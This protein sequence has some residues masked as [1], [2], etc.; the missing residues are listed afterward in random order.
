VDRLAGSVAGRVGASV[1]PAPKGRGD[2]ETAA[3]V[4]AATA[5]VGFAIVVLAAAVYAAT[6]EFAL[7]SLTWVVFR[8]GAGC[9]VAMVGALCALVGAAV[10]YPT[11]FFRSM[12][13]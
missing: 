13:R 11:V 10:A 3:L 5:L 12:R 9:T 8:L 6:T 7:T 2:V 1:G 4:G